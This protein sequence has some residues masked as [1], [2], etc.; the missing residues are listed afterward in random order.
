M[1]IE[2]ETNSCED[3]QS[4]EIIRLTNKIAEQAAKIKRL[5][6]MLIPRKDFKHLKLYLADAGYEQDTYYQIQNDSITTKLEAQA[7]YKEEAE[8]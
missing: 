2:Q 5:E 6:G 3:C 1:N 8:K 4:N 7:K